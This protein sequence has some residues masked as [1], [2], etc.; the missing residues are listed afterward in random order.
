MNAIYAGIEKRQG[1]KLGSGTEAASKTMSSRMGKLEDL[2]NQYLKKMSESPAWNRL[3]DKLG[4]LLEQLSPEGPHGQKVIASLFHTFDRLAEWV[5]KS[6][7]PENI[8]GF[9]NGVSSLIAKL[10]Q[11]PA[12]LESIYRISRDVALIYGGVKLL[13]GLDAFGKAF[14]AA[15]GGA[16][17]AL[18][19]ILAVAAAMAAIAF[20]AER[21]SATVTELGGI[22]AV[23]RD[24]VDFVANPMGV[25][26]G[27]TGTIS[28]A[29]FDAK[30]G[31]AGYKLKPQGGGKQV[32]VEFS[33][34]I[35]VTPQPGESTQ[36]AVQGAYAGSQASMQSI[37]ERAA[38]EGG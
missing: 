30:Y 5:G 7:T 19:P 34:D 24:F 3:S 33:G 38:S 4:G 25:P 6:L 16:T 27:P 36:D 17:I 14:A 18:G 13:Q 10:T 11:V 23:G 31:G 20:A 32:S 1:G 2:P 12:I 29:D 22:K 28:D 9:V 37:A 26:A 21:I 35:N 15:S 8:D